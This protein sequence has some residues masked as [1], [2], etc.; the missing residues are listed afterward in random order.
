MVKKVGRKPYGYYPREAAVIELI[1]LKARTRKGGRQP[2]P[3]QIARELDAE[4]YKSRTG[5]QVLRCPWLRKVRGKDRYECRIYDV[6][7]DVCREYP[8]SRRQAAEDGCPGI[9][10]AM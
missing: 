2:G 3:W 5:R 4:G 6:R 10:S 9:Q 1:R 8:V 7:A